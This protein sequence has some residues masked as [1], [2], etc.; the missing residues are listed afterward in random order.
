VTVIWNDI[1]ILA[2]IDAC[3]Q[4]ERGLPS[5]GA[6]L[7]RAMATERGVGVDAGDYARFLRELDV[8]GKAGLLEW[9]MVQIPA[10]VRQPS[11]NEPQWFLDHMMA[12]AL[13]YEGRNQAKGRVIQ[14]PLPDPDEDDGRMIRSMTLED[15]ATIVGTAYPEFVQALQF[16]ADSGISLDGF[17][18]D[19]V[20]GNS[21][22]SYVKH[23]LYVMA[24]DSSGRRRA[25]RNFIGAWLDDQLHTGPS[26]DQRDSI[27]RDLARQGWFVKDGWL[28]IGEPVRRVRGTQTPTPAVDQLHPNVWAAAETRWKAEHRHDAVMA[29]SK[30]ANAMLQATVGRSDVSE[31]KLVQQSFSPKAPTTTEPRLRFPDI[32]DKQTRESVTAGLLQFGVG[33]FMAIRNPVGHL[34]DQEHEMTE[35]EA[36][37]QLGAWSHFARWIERAHVEQ[38]DE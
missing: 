21:A 13:T 34:P 14:V 24:T 7:A 33:C 2:Y 26:D 27:E 1:E 37:E 20:V 11:P 5:T 30:A 15:I 28:V 17:Q 35:Q 31:V 19:K 25:L 22:S 16:L 32:A 12:F 23:A 9:Q 4:G 3:E 36:L 38:A 18:F 29:A 8:L 10:H 6:E